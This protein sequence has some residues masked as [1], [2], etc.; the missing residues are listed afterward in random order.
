MVSTSAKVM[1]ADAI[2][3]VDL[4]PLRNQSDAAGVASALHAAS[5]GLGFIYVKGHGIPA[6]VIDAARTSAYE[7]FRSTDEEKAKVVVS[8]QHRGWLRPGA[9][10][11]HDDAKVDL[12]ESFIWGAQDAEGNTVQDHPLKGPNQWPSCA[13]ELQNAAMT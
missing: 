3:V 5:Q 2:P 12:K 13:P 7:F 6:E 10:K 4:T 8:P 1:R 11:M 9:A